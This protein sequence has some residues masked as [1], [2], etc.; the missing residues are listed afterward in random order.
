MQKVEGSNPFSR[1]S[2]LMEAQ[3]SL[4]VGGRWPTTPCRSLRPFESGPLFRGAAVLGGSRLCWDEGN[5]QQG[6]SRCTSEGFGDALDDQA[7]FGPLAA[8]SEQKQ[9]YLFSERFELLD[10]QAVSGPC[11]HAIKLIQLPQHVVEARVGSHDAVRRS[12]LGAVEPN[13]CDEDQGVNLG[14]CSSGQL[15]CPREGSVALR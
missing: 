13:R 5:D 12:E 6:A 2:L 3:G 15:T 14:I 1:F 9:I 7:P 8:G 4:P 11:G 10:G